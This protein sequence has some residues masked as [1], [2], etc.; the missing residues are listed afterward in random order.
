MIENSSQAP[1][2]NALQEFKLPFGDGKIKICD[3][4]RAVAPF[5][6]YRYISSFQED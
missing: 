3:T 2:Q 6:I 4:L 1:K 5:G